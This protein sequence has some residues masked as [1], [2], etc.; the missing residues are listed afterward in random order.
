MNAPSLEALVDL[1]PWK[2]SL[3]LF[4]ALEWRG[5]SRY[6]PLLASPVLDLGCGDGQINRLVLGQWESVGVDVDPASLSKAKPLIRRVVQADARWLPFRDRSFGTF[7][8]NCAVEHL[9]ELS[10]CLAEAARVLRRGGVFIATVPSGHWKSLYCW[11][12]LFSSLGMRRLGRRI[13]D[14]HDRQMAHHNLLGPEEWAMALKKAGLSPVAFDPYL[15]P[16]GARFTT[17]VESVW[18]LPFPVPGFFRPSGTFY[19]LAG[20]LRRVGWERFWKLVFLRWVRPLY[21]EPIGP[22]GVAAGLVVVAR[23]EI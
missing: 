8:G 16:R 17:F 13:V 9:S 23:K 6:Y 19:L 20:V 2:P 14:A 18:A 4:R 12:R 5:V 22:D 7:F 21:E 10:L 3:A 15:G 1:Y 11:N